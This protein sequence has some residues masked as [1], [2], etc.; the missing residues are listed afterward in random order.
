VLARLD[1]LEKKL[2]TSQPHPLVG[3]PS[4]HAA[5]LHGGTGVS[6][7]AAQCRLVIER[8]TIPGESAIDAV[9]EVGRIL[10]SLSGEDTEFRASLRLLLA[11]E[12]FEVSR[13]SHLVQT[14]EQETR[15][16]LGHQP[17]FVGETPWMDAALLAAAGVDTVVM[18]P[19]GAG[20]HADVE[21]VDVESLV[22]LAEILRRTA[23]TY[24]Q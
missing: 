15:S 2:R 19:T 7:Y 21:W 24:C 17:E 6:T 12:P 14:L 9:E 4:L 5:V 16:L 22:S 18:G 20:A 10:G 1:G 11:R 23:E 8:R 13:S 3:P